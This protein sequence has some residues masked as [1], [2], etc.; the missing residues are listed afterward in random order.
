MIEGPDLEF[1]LGQEF[2]RLC[3]VETQLEHSQPGSFSV[4]IAAWAEAARSAPHRAEVN[5]TWVYIY[6]YTCTPP[7]IFMA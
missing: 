6:I 1:R 7:Y 4:G 3:I 5:E 2:S